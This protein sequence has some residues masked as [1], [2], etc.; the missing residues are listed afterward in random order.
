MTPD[1]E[2]DEAR[3]SSLFGNVEREVPAPDRDFLAKLRERSAE[4]FARAGNGAATRQEPP[5]PEVAGG[6][7]T[8]T[9][10]L[11]RPQPEGRRNML[12]WT[13]RGF[14]AAVA[15]IVAVAALVVNWKPAKD[16]EPTL[17][18]ILEPTAEVQTLHFQVV[19]DGK[20]ESVWFD[21]NQQAVRWDDVNGTYLVANRDRLLRVDEKENMAAPQENYLFAE[22]SEPKLQL[23]IQNA[24]ERPNLNFYA[25]LTDDFVDT[26]GNGIASLKQLKELGDLP[27]AEVK[28]KDGTNYYVYR[29]PAEGQ[30]SPLEVKAEIDSETKLLRSLETSVLKDNGRAEPVVALNVLAVNAPVDETKFAVSDTL[31]EDGRIGKI[32]D[33]QGL[34]TVR[35]VMQQRW[36][37]VATKLLLK[38]GDW[39]RTDVRGANAV[40]LK[41]VK[42]KSI[43]VGPGSLVELI[44]PTQIRLHAGEAELTV[45]E[46]ESLELLGLGEDK[47]AVK[48]TQVYRLRSEK[49]AKLDKEPV[50]LQGF[51]GTIVQESLGSLVAKDAA[52]PDA[53]NVP[54]TVGY[55]KVSV[56]IRDQIARTVI[57]ESFVNRLDVVME[58]IFYFPLPQDASI[59]GFGMWIGNELVE[60][61]VV[62]KQRAREIYETILRENRDPGLLEWSG[63]NIFKARVFPIP[64]NS[65]KRIKITYTQVLPLRGNS[66][67]YGYGL[68]SELL[69]LHPLR[70]LSLD[71]KVNS[72]LPLKNVSS[73]THTVR[74]DKT[75]HSAHL[76]FTAQEYT[77]TRDFEV[78]VEAENKQSELILIPHQRGED[79]YFLLQL[80][81]TFMGPW[82]RETLP[83][84]EPLELLILADTSASMDIGQRRKQ[85]DVVTALLG[86]LTPKDKFNLACADVECD[87]TFPNP[88]AAEGKAVSQAREFLARRVSLGWT[89]LDKAF[90]AT[91]KIQ[92]LRPNTHVV[93]IGD[94][95]ITTG[96]ADPQGF[97]QR[98]KQMYPGQGTGHAVALGSSYESSVLK[99][100]GALGGGSVRH[101]S[102]EQGPTAVALDLLREIAQ[103]GLKN[104]KVEFRGVQTARVYPEELPNVPAGAQQ[105]V[106]GLYKPTG[107]EQTGE[108]VVSGIQSGKPVKL[109]A[110]V[111]FKNAAESNS[112]IP[113]LWARQ[114]L[115]NLLAQGQSQAIKEDVISLSEEFQIMTPY[116]S[117]LVL[118][119]DADRERFKVK[120]RFK[121]RDGE[122]YFQQGRDNANYELVQQQMRRA[123]S[124]RLGLRRQALAEFARL[125]RIVSNPNRQPYPYAERFKDRSGVLLGDNYLGIESFSVNG[126]LPGGGGGF[127]F[128]VDADMPWGGGRFDGAPVDELAALNAPLSLA[129]ADAD[130]P[131]EAKESRDKLSESTI[132]DLGDYG[133]SDRKSLGG[134]IEEFSVPQGLRA[135]PA[136]AFGGSMPALAP[137]ESE[138]QFYDGA[139]KR[140]LSDFEFDERGLAGFGAFGR[141]SRG[142]R[143]RYGWGYQPSPAQYVQWV[144]NLF[145]SLPGAVKSQPKKELPSKWD[146]EIV[147][148]SKKLLRGEALTKIAGGIEI[149]RTTESFRVR[150][151]AL[152]SRYRAVELYA[153][154]AWLKRSDGDWSPTLVNWCDGTERGVMN[155]AYQLGR[156]RKSAASD[157]GPQVLELSDHSITPLHETF[158]GYNAAIAAQRDGQVT[159]SLTQ[160]SALHAETRVTI[161]TGRNVILSIQSLHRAKITSTTKFDDFVEVAGSWWAKKI[162]TFDAENRRTTLITQTV[163]AHPADAFAAR[164]K[165]ELA[166]REAVQ[167]IR[168]PGMTLAQA[169]KAR[170]RLGELTFD[171]PFTLLLHF[172]RSQQWTKA[173]EQLEQC[174][175][176]AANKPGMVWV[177]DAVLNVSRRHEELKQRLVERGTRNAER[178]ADERAAGDRLFLAE[179]MINQANG[180]MQGREML[181]FL[182]V[183]KPVYAGAQ[184]HI[185]AMRNWQERRVGGL[186][187]AGQ[188]D[189]AIALRKQLA[190][191]NPRDYGEQQNYTRILFDSGDDAAA[192]AWLKQVLAPE[193]RWE[194]SEA[195]SLRETYA[196]FLRRQGRT[197]ELVAFLDDWTKRNPESYSPYQQYLSALIQSNNTAKSDE[198]I[199]QWLKDA[200]VKGEL[201]PAVFARLTAAIYVLSGNGYGIYSDHIEAKWHKPLA[202]LILFFAREGESLGPV[203]IIRSWRFNST[204]EA[205]RVRRELGDLL[206]REIGTATIERVQSLVYWVEQGS[207]EVSGETWRKISDGMLARWVA[208]KDPDVRHQWGA[209]VANAFAYH[210]G[211]DE[212]IAFLR[213]QMNE[214]PEQ[215]RAGYAASLYGAIVAQPWQQK[216]EDEAFSLLDKMSDAEE[217]ADRLAAAVSS[218]QRLTDTMIKARNDA[219]FS[220]VEKFDE[221]K[222]TEQQAKRAEILRDARESYAA[223]LAKEIDTRGGDKTGLVGWLAAERMYLLVVLDKE[224]PQ[225][226]RDSWEFL[227]PTKPSKN[228]SLTIGIPAGDDGKPR[229]DEPCIYHNG[230]VI[231]PA[232]VAGLLKDEAKRLTDAGFKMDE[233]TLT[234]AVEGTLEQWAL[235]RFTAHAKRAGFTQ[236]QVKTPDDEEEAGLSTAERLT[237]ILRNRHLMTLGYLASRKKIEDTSTDRLLKFVDRRLSDEKEGLA[238]KLM[239]YRL[240]VALDRPQELQ[241][242][243]TEWMRGEDPI[244]QWRLSLGYLQAERG[245]LS[246][247]IRLFE[248]AE[249]ADDLGPEAYRALA[250]WYMAVNRRPDYERATIRVFQI[251]EEWRM[252]QWLS[253]M[254]NPWYRND[255]KLPT[256]LDPNVL[257]MFTALFEKSNSPGSYAYQ[258]QQFYRA[259]HDFRLLAVLADAVIGH[260]AQQVYPF[261]Q[262]MVSVLNEIRDEATADEL[263]KK[264]AAVRERAKTDVDRR[265]I[266]LLEMLVERRASEVQNQPGPHLQNSLAAM[267]RSF[268]GDWSEGEPRLMADLLA[269]LGRITQ[270]P[271]ADLQL[272]ELAILHEREKPGTFDRL[273]VARRRA[274]A[275]GSYERRKEA[276]D[277]LEPALRE[278]QIANTGILPN[279][280]NDALGVFIY[281]LNAERQ[282]ARSESILLE[283]LRHPIHGEQRLWLTRKRFEVCSEA[284]QNGGRISI[285]E[286]APLYKSL[287]KEIVAEIRATTN[288]DHRYQLIYQMTNVYRIANGKKYPTVLA[289]LKTF[290]YGPVI[291]ALKVQTNNYTSI[292]SQV[293]QTLRELLGPREALAFLIE[294]I[295]NEPAWFKYSG[296]D[297][298]N[299][300]AYSLAIWREEAKDIGNLDPRL[301]KIVL[302]EL[303]RDLELQ[304]S[305]GRYMYH[306]DHSH[307]WKEK[308][309]D[310]ARVAEEVW[311]ARK[312]SSASVQYIADYLF[313]GLERTDRAIE[314]LFIAH[315]E[316]V[317]EESGRSKLVDFLHRKQRYG[318]SVALLEPLVEE[319]PDNL[320]YRVWLMHA[321]F[322]T[323]RPQELLALLKKTDEH[324][325]ARK[326]WNEGTIAGLASSC[327]ENRLFA[328][329]AAYYKEVIPLHERTHPNRGIGNGTLSSYY[330]HQADAYSGL[331]QT[332]DAVQAACG[333]II[334]WGPTHRQ[335]TEALTALRRVLAAA[336]D[337][338]AYVKQLDADSEKLGSD[339]PMVRKAIGQVYLD[340]MQT[341]AALA[342]LQKAAELTPNDTE[343]H[344]AMLSAFDKI[345]DKRGAVGQ[346]LKSVELTRRDVALYRD[347]GRRYAELEQPRE[348]ERAYTSIVEMLPNETESH[349]ALAEVR[350]EQNRW[351]DAIRHWERVVTLRALEPTGLLKLAA[352]QIHQK[353]RDAARDTVKKLHQTPWPPRFGTVDQETRDLEQKLESLK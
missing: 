215:Y 170:V 266:D 316:K 306:D 72:A 171:V 5:P 262:Q 88:V 107:K 254:V 45:P 336:S 106:L 8:E 257:L 23:P 169:K 223:R 206:A 305:R 25:F 141:P 190:E 140:E 40:S 152:S 2:W 21:A 122:K 9:Q 127:G 58:G 188:R 252:N 130:S 181:A 46:G 310:F 92:G 34:V 167:F 348:A 161:D 145:P 278:F 187:A 243:L 210:I 49:L 3:F 240:L 323:Q 116:T 70:E 213:R 175:Q 353:Q 173:M 231:N 82:Q 103:P 242:A 345:G 162:E 52:N 143:G 69:K 81:P 15:A 153:P 185:R 159:L 296:Y 90:D 39:V 228:V 330:A 168:L 212:W 311:N 7:T 211:T 291:E 57:E 342:Q 128:D 113:R 30:R 335:R 174:E 340:K 256:E 111:S 80:T 158:R 44:S 307:F 332:A 274:E 293:S 258:L 142:G 288:H 154:A 11:T 67:R 352:A 204:E 285:G 218:L 157:L 12:A 62:E 222:R 83:D 27:P 125:G 286:G 195:D 217:E 48:G 209:L 270:K 334:S 132:E 10:N 237:K 249:S 1:D 65:E 71:V 28:K 183:I 176:I 24:P 297:G 207:G 43:I 29:L 304:Q 184:P 273:H 346:L 194:K 149:Q 95:I 75:A 302:T 239:K 281:Y 93:Y 232:E 115:D 318:E 227:E 118:E 292:V 101:V 350:Q 79:G 17:A 205:K 284:L 36:T 247:A 221:L 139:L 269:G 56:D 198:L 308:A 35:P 148:L 199:A 263:V 202:E 59:S 300:F 329:S 220:K 339:N 283:Q 251:M 219:A 123:G 245:A 351:D 186:Q 108:V 32:T 150:E 276:I 63:G 259:S 236:I 138:A 147:E 290:A 241:K 121:M 317:L 84:G 303:R 31:T 37:P 179:Q 280:A 165:D 41:L 268:K 201:P 119:T 216:Y 77:P 151:N 301:L 163:T 109:A 196:D 104:L 224:I 100:I 344:Q 327:L 22:R 134:E 200:R 192:Y 325:H 246:E 177:R 341:Q 275:L 255:G 294:R 91:F 105:I 326:L 166:P 102:G 328:Q 238:W 135:E 155:L 253:Q 287:E 250:G 114:H 312:A 193:E 313:F 331:K 89:D 289:D 133:E 343:I 53:R 78:V 4:E 16:R 349:T 26:N 55:H 164:T 315:R 85:T 60:A 191:Q 225:V 97:A 51:K 319:H 38:P 324:F 172:C 110:P 322:R 136:V 66:Y 120:R 112:F 19:R 42:Q 299:Q 178:G 208:E 124:W 235:A 50:W 64:A 279:T 203:E 214:G 117:F 320:Q 309:N 6:A 229:Y 338:D 54:L 277:L 244:S 230:Q 14:I 87:W 13:M 94:G 99:G 146:A 73:P 267:Q 333:A 265:A 74:A 182:E 126:V 129:A 61:D 298:W 271:L 47:V 272:Q 260:T 20:S 233:A 144:D 18:Q 96:D 160:R 131:D 180:I 33:T 234:I 264:I 321:Y 282:Y 337:L 68:Q 347:L 248:T 137:Y 98:V 261:L 226:A 189:E 156:V 197:G 314:I 295:E 76:E 86:A